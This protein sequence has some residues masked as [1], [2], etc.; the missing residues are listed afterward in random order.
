MLKLNRVLHLFRRHWQVLLLLLAA[1]SLA[2]ALLHPKLYLSRGVFNNIFVIDISQ[3]MNVQDYRIDGKPASR[4]EFAK[5]SIRHTL[6]NLPCGSR[7]GL[8]IFTEYRSFLL[9][10]PVETCAN[11]SEL[12]SLLENINGQM[13]WIGGSEIAKGIN[14]GFKITHKLPDKPGLIFISD[15]QEAPPIHPDHRPAI[16]FKPGEVRGMLVGAGGLTPAAIPKYDPEGNLLGFW[17]ADDVMQTDRYSD[18]GGVKALGEVAAQTEPGKKKIEGTEHLSALREAYLQTLA[19]ETGV[20]YH[21]MESV[22]NFYAAMESPRLAAANKSE[23]DVAH[24]LAIVA[25]SALSFLY[26]WPLI[27]KCFLFGR[28]MFRRIKNPA[29]AEIKS[30]AEISYRI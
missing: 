12:A 9:L 5:Q 17:G 14:F 1:L 2:A 8:G 27:E 29:R 16:D 10:A 21:R 22:I 20:G 4:L 7:A 19:G 30:A 25:L 24:F 13:A 23:T 15:G 26:A 18:G 28:A 6:K 11:F 3:S